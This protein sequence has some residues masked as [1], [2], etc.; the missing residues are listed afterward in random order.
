MSSKSLKATYRWHLRGFV[1]LNALIFFAMFA[2]EGMVAAI[3]FRQL[4]GLVSPRAVLG[5]VLPLITLV[6]DGIV[7]ADAKAV[8]VYWRRKNP[9]PGSEAFTKHGAADPRVDM[10]VLN[11]RCGSLPKAA[12]EQNQLWYKLFKAVEN[13]PSVSQAHRASLLTRDLATLSL[14]L[15]PLGA[16][17]AAVLRVGTVPWVVLVGVLTLQFIV[18][19]RVAANNGRRFVTTVLAEAT[20]SAD[21]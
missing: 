17:F 5:L 21:Q 14:S 12:D 7:P 18:L 19:R 15:I 9:L 13:R 20:A 6:L 8:L 2:G 3:E 10:K 11:E 16:I 1:A 4:Q